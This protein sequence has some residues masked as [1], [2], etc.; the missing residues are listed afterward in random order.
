MEELAASLTP[1]DLAARAYEL[2]EQFRPS[3]PAGV[4]GWG[5][6]GDLDLEK[7]RALT[8]GGPRR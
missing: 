6:P 5:A 8:R 1:E 7:L 2:Y 4:R 3:V